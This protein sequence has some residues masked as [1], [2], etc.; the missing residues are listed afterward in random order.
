MAGS[1]KGFVKDG[2]VMKQFFE[3]ACDQKSASGCYN[4][5]NMLNDGALIPAN[6]TSAQN[7]KQKGA[8][9]EAEASNTLR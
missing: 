1:G 6:K 9:I 4:L 7:A 3:Q 8:A 2:Q 5:S